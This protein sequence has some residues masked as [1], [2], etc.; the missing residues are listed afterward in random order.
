MVFLRWLC[1]SG[2]VTTGSRFAGQFVLQVWNPT[3]ATIERSSSWI[4]EHA[5][6][7]NGATTFLAA[8]KCRAQEHGLGRAGVRNTNVCS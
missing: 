1:T 2:A 8:T 4:G 3:F 6:L 7:S 5:A